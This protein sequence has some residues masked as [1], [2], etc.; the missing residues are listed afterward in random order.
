VRQAPGFLDHYPLGGM[1]IGA[2]IDGAIK[3]PKLVVYRAP[4]SS[5]APHARLSIAPVIA[6]RAKGVAIS[7]VF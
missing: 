3:G 2:L 4:G 1:G 6:P 5:G 7:F